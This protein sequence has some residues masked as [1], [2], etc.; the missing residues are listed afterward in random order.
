[1]IRLRLPLA[2]I[3]CLALLWPAASGAGQQPAKEV[4]DENVQEKGPLSDVAAM[5]EASI[6][7]PVA[8]LLGAALAFRPKR[9]GTP[10]RNPPVIQTQIL[11][12]VVGA[13]VMMVVG[14]SL[15]RAFGI[16]GAAGLIRYRAKID[17]P[18]DAGVMLA[19]LG[20]GLAAGVGLFLLAAFS[21]LFFLLLLA[22][23]ESLNEGQKLFD[24]TV[25]ADEIGDLRSG[26]E[27]LLRRQ[28]IDHE[29]RSSSEHALCYAVRLPLN[30]RTDRVSS[31]I[32]RL[33]RG[34]VKSV[35]WEE[36]KVK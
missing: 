7:L 17:D 2:A 14:S 23:V 18:K 3:L 20:V 12:A 11:L 16:V 24:L 21:T 35:G 6:R 31:A 13:L 36:R 33:A 9:R 10:P 32:H 4:L 30:R 34:R 28:A 27:S 8:S 5:L 1:M 19:A 29:L 26:L 22:V 15:A 25:E